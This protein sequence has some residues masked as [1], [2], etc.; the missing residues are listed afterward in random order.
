MP[1]ES[2][3]SSCKQC[4]FHRPLIFTCITSD[5]SRV[6]PRKTNHKS[7]FWQSPITNHQSLFR[8]SPITNHSFGCLLAVFGCLLAVFGLFLLQG[9]HHAA[10]PPDVHVDLEL[11]LATVIVHV[12]DLPKHIPLRPPHIMDPSDRP[13]ASYVAVGVPTVDAVTVIEVYA[14]RKGSLG[15]V[16]P[17][18][19]LLGPVHAHKPVHLAAVNELELQ[20]KEGLLE[21]SDR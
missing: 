19:D 2:L 8:Q 4:G 5:Q 13:H 15:R 16:G 9:R 7:L 14:V 1:W 17:L 3:T 12:P 18:E 6:H 20:A 21:T 11:A 10:D